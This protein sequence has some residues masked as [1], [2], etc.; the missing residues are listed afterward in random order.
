MRVHSARAPRQ[1]GHFSSRDLKMEAGKEAA[2]RGSPARS[3]IFGRSSSHHT[4]FE[5]CLTSECI[6]TRIVP[7]AAQISLQLSALTSAASNVILCH[8]SILLHSS[9]FSFSC[10][11]IEAGNKRAGGPPCLLFCQRAAEHIAP[12]PSNQSTVSSCRIAPGAVAFRRRIPSIGSTRVV[13]AQ[14]RR[15]RLS[16]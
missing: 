12:C 10:L 16:T 14:K 7:T 6:D 3:G 15:W 9:P 4:F 5:T 2:K 11:S 1:N 13:A 8:I